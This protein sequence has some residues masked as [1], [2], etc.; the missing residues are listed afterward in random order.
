MFGVGSMSVS[1]SIRYASEGFIQKCLVE[2][3]KLDIPRE[4]ALKEGLRELNLCKGFG[5]VSLLELLPVKEHMAETGE[6][7]M[8]TCY[9][10]ILEKYTNAARGAFSMTNLL[11][12][13]VEIFVGWLMRYFEFDDLQTL[14]GKK[15]ASCLT[16]AGVGFCTGGP[17]GALASF[18]FWAVSWMVSVILELIVLPAAKWLL[19]K[20][21]AAVNK[22]IAAGTWLVNKMIGVGTWLVEKIEQLAVSIYDCLK[23]LYE[24][25]CEWLVKIV[26]KLAEKLK[27][28]VVELD[29]QNLKLASKMKMA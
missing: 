12:I 15:L 17:I 21:I 3:V 28:F 7:L 10:E 6:N 13:P 14:M 9:G 25:G 19:D 24:M 8:L 22:T 20:T 23:S 27:E 11:Q 5:P 4:Q 2:M 16:A 18:V 29:L 26:E 1:S